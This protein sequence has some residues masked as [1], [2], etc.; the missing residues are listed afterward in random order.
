MGAGVLGGVVEPGPA[1]VEVVGSGVH[2][3]NNYILFK[4]T[5]CLPYLP[6]EF[7]LYS[8]LLMFAWE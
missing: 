7:K 6:G 3:P 5:Y 2:A 4:L 1:V 8:L